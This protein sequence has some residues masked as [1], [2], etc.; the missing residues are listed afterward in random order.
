MAES[1]IPIYTNYDFYVPSFEIKL[2]GQD[3]KEE[4]LRDV[5]SVSY[6]DSLDKLDSCQFTINNWDAGQRTFKYSDSAQFNPGTA[7][8]LRMGY[9]DKGGTTLM[10]RGEIVSLSPDFPA[11]GQPTLQIRALNQ[12]YQLHFKQLTQVFKDKT[13]SQI[14]KAILDKIVKDQNSKKKADGKPTLNLELV[15]TAENQTIEK[16]YQY[17]AINN[18]YPISFLME[19]ARH[20]GYDLYLEEGKDEQPARLHFH[21]PTR[22]FPAP[23]KLEWGKTLINFKPTLAIKKQVEKVTVRGWNP[24]KKE[25]VVGEAVWYDLDAKSLP[26]VAALSAADSALVGSEEVIADQPIESKAEAEQLAK[27]YLSE[28]AKELVTGSGSTVGLPELR[29]GRLVY[30]GGLGKRFT[31]R[32]LVTNSTHSLGDSGYSTQFEARLEELMEIP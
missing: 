13:D 26:D 4:V 24:K 30:I 21:P 28:K 32:Y 2:K 5:I 18:E 3:I 1:P 17:I 8:E 29:A 9:A 25:E 6:T 12:L 19:R 16:P 15:T 20:N 11:G 23:Y 22:K 10:L 14:A 7:I 31:G 27:K